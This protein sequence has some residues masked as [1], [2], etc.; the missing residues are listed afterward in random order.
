MRDNMA[1]MTKTQ[2]KRALQQ[3][4]QKAFKLAENG[5]IRTDDLVA[6]AK[7]TERCLK[8]MK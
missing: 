1:K 4:A 2:A 8:R 6:M 5:Y 3:M 7:I